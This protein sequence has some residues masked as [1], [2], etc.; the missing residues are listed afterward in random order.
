M[1]LSQNF[2]ISNAPSHRRRDENGYLFVDESPVLQAGIL[3]YY[4]H[5]LL[6][7]DETTIDGVS[8]QPDEIYKVYVP[9]E[10]LN[11]IRLEFGV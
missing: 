5:E 2:K 8:V 11:Y 1:F 10:E 9:P 3:E 6:G 7:P 4:G